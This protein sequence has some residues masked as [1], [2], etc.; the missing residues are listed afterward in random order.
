MIVKCPEE[1]E[2]GFYSFGGNRNRETFPNTG[3][4]IRTRDT[5]ALFFAVTL[6]S[7]AFYI[8]AKK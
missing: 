1:R 8:K 4:N 6:V 3:G 7:Y 5:H 2:R